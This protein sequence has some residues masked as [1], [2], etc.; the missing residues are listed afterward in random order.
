MSARRWDLTPRDWMEY[1]FSRLALGHGVGEMWRSWKCSLGKDSEPGVTASRGEKP[2]R[3]QKSG[4]E[5]PEEIK[6]R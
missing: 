3:W 1:S 4:E 2:V 6:A 5:S